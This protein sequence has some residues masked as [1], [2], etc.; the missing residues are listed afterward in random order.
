MVFHFLGYG[1]GGPEAISCIEGLYIIF[2]SIDCSVED[3]QEKELH[4]SRAMCITQIVALPIN[5]II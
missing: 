4:H 3:W 5:L 1:R 2:K